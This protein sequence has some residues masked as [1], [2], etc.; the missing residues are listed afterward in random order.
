MRYI[1][2]LSF[3]FCTII[4]HSSDEEVQQEQGNDAPYNHF[5]EGDNCFQA[6]QSCIGDACKK[7]YGYCFGPKD[8][9]KKNQ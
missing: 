8:S 7:V 6:L 5:I 3:L 4:A 9:S 1:A 2:I